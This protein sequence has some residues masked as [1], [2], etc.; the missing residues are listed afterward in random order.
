MFSVFA[1]R[2]SSQLSL[3]FFSGSINSRHHQLHSM[4]HKSNSPSV[5]KI[6]A[7]ITGAQWNRLL[8]FHSMVPGTI[9]AMQRNVLLR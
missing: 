2:V 7:L 8:S 6:S 9:A 4:P 3:M 5:A 1:I